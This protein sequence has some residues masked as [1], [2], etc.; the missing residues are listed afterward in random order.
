MSDFLKC[1]AVALLALGY[2]LL[3]YQGMAHE[4]VPSGKQSREVLT[5][6]VKA[7][8]QVVPNPTVGEP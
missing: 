5:R 3:R 4:L 2:K 1:R 8:A 7:R 6:G